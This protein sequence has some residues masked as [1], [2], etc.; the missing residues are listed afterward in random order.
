[1]LHDSQIL[2]YGSSFSDQTL[3]VFQVPIFCFR[4]SE[5]LFSFD[6]NSYSP[7]TFWFGVFLP[8]KSVEH[9]YVVGSVKTWRLKLAFQLCL[10]LQSVPPAL[11]QELLLN[12]K[13]R[14]S[15]K[16]ELPTEV[17]QAPKNSF[18]K[19]S[20]LHTKNELKFHSRTVR[21][22]ICELGTL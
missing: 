7:T 14:V 4:F 13:I 20:K 19:S 5:R 6:N 16:A 21:K 9:F 15:R 12:T 2:V 18:K 8:R 3:K 10:L 17:C 1:M 11:V 22:L